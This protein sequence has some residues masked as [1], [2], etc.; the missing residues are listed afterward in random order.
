MHE[1]D[2][3]YA[4]EVAASITSAER[5]IPVILRATGPV[6]SVTDLGGGTGAWLQ[7]FQEHGVDRVRLIDTP[8]ARSGLLV[9]AADFDAADLNV[10]FPRVSRCDLAVCVECAEHLQPHRSAPLVEWLTATADRVVFSGA[11]P[12]QAGKNHINLRPPTFWSDLFHAQGFVRRDV[13]RSHII[14]EA[15]IPWWYRQNL[16]LYVKVGVSLATDEEDFLSADFELVNIGIMYD[17]RNIRFLE[18][19]RA[20]GPAFMASIRRKLGSSDE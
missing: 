6:N 3:A 8:D 17:L 20:L 18:R 2:Y 9:D 19:L 4:D 16:F 11:V 15:E 14:H 7:V 10:D 12:G 1:N 5:I 13:L